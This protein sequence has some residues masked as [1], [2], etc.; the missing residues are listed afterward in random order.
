[1]TEKEQAELDAMLLRLLGEYNW[2]MGIVL[3]CVNRHFHAT[4][5]ADAL[6][7]RYRNL[8]EPPATT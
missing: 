3:P 8:Q 5:S 2:R 7:E 1:M 6:L 4:F